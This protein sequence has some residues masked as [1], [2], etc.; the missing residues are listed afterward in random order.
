MLIIITAGMV[1]SRHAGGTGEG[2]NQSLILPDRGFVVNLGAMLDLLFLHAPSVYDFRQRATL[3]GPISDLVPSTPVYDM[4]PIGF[5]TMLAH[6]QQ[7]GFQVR[8]GNLAARMVRSERFNPEHLVANVN[9]RAYGI[10]LHWLPHAHGALEVAKLV[11]KHH[12]GKP[13]I[14]GGYS[15]TY[16][17]E[18]LIR[19]P[20]VDY[21]L[22]G[23]STEEP[24]ERLM[25]HIVA[26]TEPRDVANLTWQESTGEIHINPLT[27]IP[28][29]L[30]NLT[31]DYRPM[32]KSVVRN[33]DLLN[34]VPFSHWLEYPIM[35][36]LTVKGCTQNCTI[37]GGSAFAAR[38]L[39]GRQKPAYRSPELL[40]RDVRRLG[41]LS[42][43]P[44]FLLG[45]LRQAGMDYARRFLRAVQGFDGPVIVEFFGPVDRA[46]AEEFA[47]ALPN[48][49]VEFSPESHDPAVRR[50]AGKP[51]SNEGIEQTIISCLDVGARRFDL[52]FMIGLSQQTPASALETVDYCRSLLKQFD[53]GR[54]VP[55]TSPLAP[56]LDPGSRAYEQPD[57][58]GY[59]RHASTLADHRELLLQPTWRDIL[60]Y[61]TRWM[62]RQSIVDVTYEAGYR[63]NRL[64]REAGLVSTAMAEETESRIQAARG[65]MQEIDHLVAT[66]S[67]QELDAALMA[68]K[69]RIDQANTSTI[70]D[71]EELD[72][73]VGLVP[74][75]IINLA[76]IGLGL[77]SDDQPAY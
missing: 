12:P 10:D 54:L 9:A 74:F 29:T 35:A 24:L 18:E 63:L 64:K 15:S 66:K 7:A 14:F 26:G 37:C 17:H 50:A 39:S 44:I 5:S 28:D 22:R 72:A 43:A 11:K 73:D 27:Y 47:A 60:S 49:I 55:F 33:L 70:C 75:K 46:Y 59:I 52:F 16:F 38:H 20:Y 19:L 2:S 77:E 1:T 8:I 31:L 13:V 71:K 41:K 65:L 6:L 3:W 57:R 34:Q 53:D 25:M 76:Q 48:F 45:D 62:D 21:V 36:S 58:F 51:Y 32:V 42:R 67:A 56:F 4:Y 69:P 30:D 68:L 23:D 40:A 61:E